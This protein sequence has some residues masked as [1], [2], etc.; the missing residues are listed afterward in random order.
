M[1]VRRRVNR[2]RV[3]TKSY[4]KKGQDEE[5]AENNAKIFLNINSILNRGPPDVLPEEE[6]TSNSIRDHRSM[7]HIVFEKEC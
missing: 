3:I 2:N 6:I 4:F 7:H 1:A 5:L